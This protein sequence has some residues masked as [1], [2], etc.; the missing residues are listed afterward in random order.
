M[1]PSIAI[2]IGPLLPWFDHRVQ[3]PRY[4]PVSWAPIAG[5][6]LLVTNDVGLVARR[7]HG[8]RR[9]RPP[10]RHRR[11]LHDVAELRTL[12]SSRRVGLRR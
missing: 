4:R 8:Y 2:T 12:G 11:R 3:I 6:V 7:D 10:G 5:T 1:L 9:R